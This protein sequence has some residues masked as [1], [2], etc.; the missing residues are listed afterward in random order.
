MIRPYQKSKSKGLL[1][2]NGAGSESQIQ[3][4]Q[5]NVTSCSLLGHDAYLSFITGWHIIQ[6]KFLQFDI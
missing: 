1:L 4:L 2:T 6:D 3:K 5:V